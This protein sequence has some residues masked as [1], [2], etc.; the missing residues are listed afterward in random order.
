MA[1]YIVRRLAFIA[2]TMVLASIL[3]FAAT[4]IIPGDIATMILGRFASE[5][6]K[7]NL[8]EELGLNRPVIIQY[9]DWLWSFIRGDWGRSLSTD[10]LVREVVFERLRSSSILAA[11]AF[12]IY[13]P[14]GIVLG[15]IAGLRRNSWLDNLLSVGSLS[16]IGLPEFVSGVILIYVF[17]LKLGWLP[18]QSMVDYSQGFIPNISMLILPAIT[19][20]LTSIAYILRMQRSSTIEVLEMDYVRTANLKGLSA[21]Q[22]LFGHVLRNALLPTVT[23]VAIGIGW[24]IGGLIITET[25]FSYPGLGRM[26]LFAIQRRD[27]PLIQA[28]AMLIVII[29]GLANLAAD[30]IYA[31]LN[32]R[33]AY[34]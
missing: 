15:L 24:L 4:Q 17:A 7:F 1:R 13:V 8:R 11:C 25:V 28:V 23:V 33:I 19:I 21:R 10:A 2:L 9:L 31:Y 16:F 6:A 29:V 27:L 32:P 22:V 18:A 30:I 26:L 20:S 12:I 34:R 3:I 5:Q 14:L